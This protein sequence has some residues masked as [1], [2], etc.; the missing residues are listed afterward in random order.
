MSQKKYPVYMQLNK[1]N[2]IQPLHQERKIS[3]ILVFANMSSSALIDCNLFVLSKN[4]NLKRKNPMPHFFPLE[5]D[6][7]KKRAAS[8]L[9]LII[10]YDSRTHF[11][12]KQIL[13]ICSLLTSTLNLTAQ[14]KL[15]PIFG[16]LLTRLNL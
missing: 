11:Y 7:K 15:W 13:L 1:R 14:K 6:D 5:L 16:M 9:S 2:M 12:S 4:M 8:M 3:I 10:S